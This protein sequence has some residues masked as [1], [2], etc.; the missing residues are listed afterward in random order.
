MNQQREKL[1]SRLGFILLSAECA[2]AAETCGNPVDD[3]AVRRGGLCWCMCGAHSA[4][5]AVHDYGVRNGARLPGERSSVLKLEK[6]GISGISTAIRLAGNEAL[7]RSILLSPAGYYYSSVS[8]WK[9]ADL[10]FVGMI[11]NPGVNVLYR[12]LRGPGLLILTWPQKG[13]SVSQIYDDRTV[14][15]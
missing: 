9:T 10:G 2:I 12:P 8:H 14:S 7:M 1:G 4:G 5:A 6:P 11:T 13:L 15:F 3:G